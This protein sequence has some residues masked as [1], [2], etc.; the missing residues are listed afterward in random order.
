MKHEHEKAF[1]PIYL[2]STDIM[3]D[4]DSKIVEALMVSL[5]ETVTD[6]QRAKSKVDNDLRLK[7]CN[8]CPVNRLAIWNEE[9]V[10]ES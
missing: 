9:E 2:M 3:F 7:A 10:H 6:E 5:G 1:T 4:E 8:D